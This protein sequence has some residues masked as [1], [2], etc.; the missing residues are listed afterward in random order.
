MECGPESNVREVAGE[1]LVK[2]LQAI[3]LYEADFYFYKQFKFGKE[4]M[5][6]I[7]KVDYIPG[8]L[9]SH[10]ESTVEDAKFDKTLTS[11]LSRQARQLMTVVL[12]DAANC[13]DR[14]NHIIMLLVWMAALQGN[15]PAMVAA[16][17]SLQMMKIY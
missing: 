12:A 14:V 17:I 16:L 10:K 13:Y 9:F 5:K 11:D 3:Q 8:E 15:I 2:K 1:C 6:A 7:N 4:G